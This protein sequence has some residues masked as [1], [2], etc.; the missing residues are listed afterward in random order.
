M[1]DGAFLG[2]DHSAIT[3]ADADRSIA[4]YAALGF[5]LHGRQ[6]NRGVEQQR[7]DGLAVPVRVEVVSLVPP[8][9]APPHLE[10][11]CYRSPAATR[12]PAPD[13]SRFATVLCLSGEADAAAPV[14]D[15]DGH[16][17]LRGAF[18]QA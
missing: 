13:G 11:L 3:V 16:R 2:I 9:G 17:L 18:T 8:G 15:P 14:A 6:Q 7:L 5:R 1:P 4:F 10:L 12:A